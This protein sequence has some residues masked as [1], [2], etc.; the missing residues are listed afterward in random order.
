L[1]IALR[2]YATKLAIICKIT[3]R[4]TLIVLAIDILQTKFNVDLF[5]SDRD[6]YYAQKLMFTRLPP[7]NSIAPIIDVR[8]FN[9]SLI[10]TP[11]LPQCEVC[12]IVPVKDEA[13]SLTQTLAALANQTCLNGTPLDPRSYEIILLANNCTD[14]SARIAHRFAT[15][16]PDLVLHI[17]EINL[18]PAQAYIGHVRKLLM[19]EAHDRLMSLERRQGMIASTDGDT[20]VAATWIAANMHEIAS[21]VDAVGGRI[22]T[23]RDSRHQLSLQAKTFL[24]QEVGYRSLVAQMESYLDPDPYDPLPRH[25]QH[26][27]ASLAVTAQMYA[28][29]GGIPPVRTPEDEAFY[30]SLVRVNA[31]FRHSPLVKVTTSAR[32]TGRSPVGLAN[33]L[34]KWTAMSVDATFKVEPAAVTILRFQSRRR[35]RSMWQRRA[36]G[37]R[38]SFKEIE[39]LAGKLGVRSDWLLDELVRTQTFGGLFERV[40]QYQQQ[41]CLSR[42]QPIDVKTAMR[43]LR[44]YLVTLD[45]KVG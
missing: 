25:Y 4:Q 40:T 42:W 36:V 2:T 12:V 10:S 34:R 26:Y 41:D 32:S 19:D 24:L 37:G 14:E 23:D 45:R 11:P 13:Q 30:Q 5:G 9:Q 33:Q 35:L 17:A 7:Q 39:P 1:K 22:I 6:R 44:Q 16:H 8:N 3:D 20:Q 38:F 21:G 27:G 31:R 43:E 15:Q 18:P 28:K 29:A